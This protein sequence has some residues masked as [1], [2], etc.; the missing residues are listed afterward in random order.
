MKKIIIFGS[1]GLFKEHYYWINECIR[2]NNEYKIAAI[3]SLENSK[4]TFFDLPV[5]NENEIRH[6]SEIYLHIAVGSIEARINIISKYKDYNFYTLKH[7]S[8]IISEGAVIG[9]GCT[10]SPNVV[11][12][13]NAKIGNFNLFNFNSSI[14]HDCVS[15][16]NNIFSP[17]TLITG[18]CKI[19]DNNDFGSGSI[20]VPKIKL[21]NNNIIGANSTLTKDFGNNLTLVGSPA[22]KYNK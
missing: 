17:G 11:I 12:A 10:I 18:W 21:G 22:K 5:I 13:G 14:S 4:K 6:S 3:V 7:P 20:M 8:A 15:G 1:G 16:E 19:G 2:K 9:K